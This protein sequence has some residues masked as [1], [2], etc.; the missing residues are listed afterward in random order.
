MRRM[1]STTKDDARTH[2]PR[3]S[4]D[5]LQL[6]GEA[7]SDLDQ[8]ELLFACRATNMLSKD[9]VCIKGIYVVVDKPK[10][11]S[12]RIKQLGTWSKE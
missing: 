1:M 9:F 2:S 4:A 3:L 7:V 6:S 12:M 10:G 5:R 11:S 8:E